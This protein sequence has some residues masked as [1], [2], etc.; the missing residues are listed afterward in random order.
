MMAAA[1]Q[2]LVTRSPWLAWGGAVQ[3]GLALVMAL[4]AA[5][6]GRLVAGTNLWIKPVKFALSTGLFQWTVAWLLGTL[7][8]A[9]SSRRAVEA[10]VFATMTIEMFFIILQ[11]ARGVKSHFNVDSV[12]GSA[13]FGIMGIAIALNTLA[14]AWLLIE[15]LGAQPEIPGSYL[16]GI[17]AGL[18]IF[19]LASIQGGFMAASGAHTVGAPDGGP[20]LP[21][22]N[23][24]TGYGDLRVAHFIGLHAL[25]FLPLMGWLVRDRLPALAVWALGGL[26]LILTLLTWVQAMLGQPL[27]RR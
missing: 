2:E 3:M 7:L 12:T 24:S 8:L 17:R 23:W 4:L 15:S 25:Q 5:F 6:D 13:I 26:H 10:V 22:L 21:F 14:L 27:W 1:W 18:L 9:A 16:A 11:A 19:L 20:G